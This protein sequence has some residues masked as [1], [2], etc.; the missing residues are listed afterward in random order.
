MKNDKNKIYYNWEDMESQ[1]HHIQKQIYA[2]NW[3]PDYVVGLTRGGLTPAV[4]F[5]HWLGVPMNTLHVRLLDGKEEDC[6]TNTWMPE[7]AIGVTDGE[8][9]RWHPSARKNILIVDDI[10]DSGATIN[11]IKQNWESSCYAEDGPWK[12]VWGNNVRFATLVNNTNSDAEVDYSSVDIDKLEHP[13]TWI[14]FPWEDW[15]QDHG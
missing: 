15:E 1:V 9:C 4:L 10:N 13:D 2:D 8:T 7:D 6:E 5:S 12:T 11:W 3:R 14:V